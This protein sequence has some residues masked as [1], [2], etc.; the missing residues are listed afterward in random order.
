MVDYR[1]LGNRKRIGT[2]LQN[3]HIHGFYFTVDNP[4]VII[5]R[6]K[7]TSGEDKAKIYCN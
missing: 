2:R 1:N 7:L 5:H 3:G 4:Q 6:F